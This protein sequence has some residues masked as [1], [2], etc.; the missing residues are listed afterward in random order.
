LT[1]KIFSEP[2][3]WAFKHDFLQR[4]AELDFRTL[5]KILACRESS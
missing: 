5:K 1:N 4:K 3:L 2:F